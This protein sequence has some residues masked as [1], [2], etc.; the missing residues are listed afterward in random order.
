MLAD[1]TYCNSN[2]NWKK[3][4]NST[5]VAPIYVPDPLKGFERIPIGFLCVDSKRGT[6]NED[7]HISTLQIL[8]KLASFAFDEA[9][10]QIEWSDLDGKI[11]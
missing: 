2:P 3:F 4:Y 11:N 5:L 6:F 9:Y 1:D 10:Q 7:V 8:A